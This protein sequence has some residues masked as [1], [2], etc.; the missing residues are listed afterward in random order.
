[1]Y[2]L[3]EKRF[4]TVNYITIATLYLLILAGGIVRSTGSGM[5]CPDWPKCFDRYI[6]PTD[7]SQLPENYQQKY[8]QRRIDKNERFAKLM[9]F[10]GYHNQAAEIR[11]DKSIAE[12]EDFNAAKTWTEYVNR[13][14]G[15]ILG[16]LMLACVLLSLTYLKTSKRIFLLS[17]LNVILVIFQAWLG[18]IVV[19]T[20]LLAWV[21]T[22]HMLVAI[23]ILAVCI[24]TY[25]QGII[26][27]NRKVLVKQSAGKVR[28]FA[29]FVLIL[30]IIQITIGTQVRENIDA[31][32]SVMDHLNRSEWV[33][34]VGIK[35][36]LHRD[37]AIAVLLLN[38]VLFLMVRS[39]YILNGYQFRY[40][41]YTLFLVVLQILIGLIL[42]Y[43]GLP[44]V[45][46]A[47]HIVLATLL[48]GAQF[49]LVLLLK[50]NKLYSRNLT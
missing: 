43:L 44:P 19:S 22:V 37:L 5:G 49:Y 17:T 4:L 26:I 12:P 9:A 46:Q 40:V 20:N 48:F 24:Y 6:P 45:A 30:T 28:A 33:S 1:M 10:F 29:I 42:S 32:S 35:F 27:R 36:N 34:Q 16:V 8:V 7:A 3:N 11:N 2:S 14:I 38:V 13:L 41:S 31:I 18:S 47:L 15:A 39:K 23:A 21:V 25:F 50:K